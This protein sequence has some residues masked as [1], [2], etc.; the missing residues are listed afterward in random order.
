MFSG[1]ADSVLV[2]RVGDR[3]FKAAS[4]CKIQHNVHSIVALEYLADAREKIPHL[5]LDTLEHK[6]YNMD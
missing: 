2:N 5:A 1:G 6:F 4:V 3:R